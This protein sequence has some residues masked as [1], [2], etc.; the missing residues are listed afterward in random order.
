MDREAEILQLPSCE[1]FCPSPPPPA[2][3]DFGEW[4]RG[5]REY[6]L[7]K[8]EGQKLRGVEFLWFAMFLFVPEGAA[9]KG[10][11]FFRKRSGNQ[12]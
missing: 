6:E 3:L 7:K 11:C 2:G 4:Q 10:S 1:M 5:G 8:W 12:V 9:A